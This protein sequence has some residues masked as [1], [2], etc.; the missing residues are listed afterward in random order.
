MPSSPLPGTD[1]TST[2]EGTG[3]RLGSVEWVRQTKGRLAPTEQRRLIAA[4][5]TTHVRNAVGRTRLA[6]GLTPGRHRVIDPAALTPPVT[7]LAREAAAVAADLL[8]RELLEHSHRTFRFAR[9]LGL[10]E[11]VEV[12]DDL[13]FAAAMLHDTGLLAQSDGTDFTLRAAD[14]V[15]E[16]ASRLGISAALTEVMQSA[17][18]MHPSPGV[19]MHDGPVAYLLSAGAAVDVVGLR[20]WD[21]PRETV[22]DTLA[23]HPRHN[24]KKFFAA[25]FKQEAL[26]VPRGRVRLLHAY[27]AFGPAIRL[28]PF[29]E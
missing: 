14:L 5:A 27:G 16:V 7:P 2:H 4:I 29:R 17:I 15:G 10:V 9:A 25:A 22:A 18:T 12:D 11:H 3:P 13:L 24:F 19:R 1:P 23:L 28:A 26:N 8:P 20:I 21:L 6:V